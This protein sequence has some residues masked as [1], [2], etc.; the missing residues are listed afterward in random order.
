MTEINGLRL[1]YRG[2]VTG[3]AASYVWLAAAMLVALLGEGDAL[4]P[5][6]TIAALWNA[7]RL[8]PIDAPWVVVAWALLQ[9]SAA[10]IGIGFAYFV[11]R[12]FT[13]RPTLLV[14]APCFALLAWLTLAQRFTVAAGTG[15]SPVAQVALVAGSVLYGVM[16]G[17]GVPVR[18]EVLRGDYSTPVSSPVT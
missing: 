18:G 4:R 2:F 15:L 10:G 6:R 7:G 1:A 5:L 9:V 3:L 11:A 13:V 12:Y 16:L 8:V 17:V 14:A